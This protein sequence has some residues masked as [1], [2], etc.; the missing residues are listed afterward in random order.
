MFISY[1]HH[2]VTAP[3]VGNGDVLSTQVTFESES[4][5]FMV[6]TRLWDLDELLKPE[7]R[8]TSDIEQVINICLDPE[9]DIAELQLITKPH[10]NQSKRT[11]MEVIHEIKKAEQPCGVPN[12]DVYV[13]TLDSEDSYVMRRSGTPRKY[14]CK[15]TLVYEFTEDLSDEEYC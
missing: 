15:E 12:D 6:S 13:V 3:G 1:V 14:L 10:L 11:K 8:Y 5:L 7:T 4:P 2:R 9:Y